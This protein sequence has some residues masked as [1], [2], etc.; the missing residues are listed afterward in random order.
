MACVWARSG[1]WLHRTTP[2]CHRGALYHQFLQRGSA[3]VLLVIDRFV[4]ADTGHSLPLWCSLRILGEVGA[5]TETAQG[6]WS[7]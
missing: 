1:P 5:R 3:C 2:T 6:P 7:A 4:S